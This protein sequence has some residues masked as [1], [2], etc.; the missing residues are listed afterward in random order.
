MIPKNGYQFSEK[1]MRNQESVRD[2]QGI[3]GEHALCLVLAP[4]LQAD[5]RRELLK[6]LRRRG[7]AA[8]V[9]DDLDLCRLINP[10]GRQPFLCYGQRLF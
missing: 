10:G 7:D 2:N 3:Q 5:Y 6:E 1:I 9:V 4:G 8:G